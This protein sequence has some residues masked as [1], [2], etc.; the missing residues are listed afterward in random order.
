MLFQHTCHLLIG[1][2]QREKSERN[3]LTSTSQQ[4]GQWV[5]IS[6]HFL[7]S[8]PQGALFVSCDG[9]W[10]SNLFKRDKTTSELAT[11]LNATARMA[12]CVDE[13]VV[14]ILAM[15]LLQHCWYSGTPI[16][17]LVIPSWLQPQKRQAEINVSRFY[18]FVVLSVCYVIRGQKKKHAHPF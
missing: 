2:K 11:F 1:L 3:I 17:G 12:K 16:E 9:L 4:D 10:L 5:W 13:I 14:C 15:L 18:T 7:S 6:H 8:S